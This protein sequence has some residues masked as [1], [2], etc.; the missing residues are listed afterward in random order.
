MSL[1]PRLLP[2]ALL[3]SAAWQP[4]LALA[5][6]AADAAA[7]PPPAV[8]APWVKRAEQLSLEAATAAVAGIAGARVEVQAGALDPRLKLAPCEQVDIYLPTGA[9]A[10]GATRVGLRCISGPSRWNVFM[11]LTVRVFAPAVL[12]QGPMAAGTVLGPEHLLIEQAEWSAANSPAFARP[13]SVV[14]RSL[15]RALSA[16]ATLRESDL[17]RR[18]WFAVGDVVR[19]VAVGDGFSISSDGVALT[20]GFE[21]QPAKIRTDGGRTLTGTATGERRIQVSP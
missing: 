5:P 9:R 8:L 1:L 11:P 20:P 17:K 12:A 10:W 18:Q 13:E 14:G 6:N 19:V 4:A 21:G 15:G 16:G 7:V 2:L 3:S